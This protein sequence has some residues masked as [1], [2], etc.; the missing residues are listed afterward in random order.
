MPATMV[1]FG[2]APRSDV[3]AH[4]TP[5]AAGSDPI[6][7]TGTITGTLPYLAPEQIEGRAIDPRTELPRSTV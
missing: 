4:D 1:E 3:P 7:T 6:T 2:L 5:T